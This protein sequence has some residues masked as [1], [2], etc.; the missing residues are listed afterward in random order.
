MPIAS[1]LRFSKYV[2][3]RAIVGQNRHPFPRPTQTPWVR[4][5]CQYCVQIDASMV[6]TTMRAEPVIATGR[7]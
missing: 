7:K 3:T 6:P 2:D 4:I 5:N 1:D